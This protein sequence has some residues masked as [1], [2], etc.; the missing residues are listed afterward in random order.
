MG[1]G[2]PSSLRWIDR[3]S[4]LLVL[5]TTLLLL[6]TT[7]L[8][9]DVRLI[10]SA[11]TDTFPACAV[12]CQVLTQAQDACVPPSAPVSNQQTYV[13][14]F[15]QSTLLSNLKNNAAGVCGT[16][17]S[18]QAELVQLQKWYAD[19]CASGGK[20]GAATTTNAAPTPSRVTYPAPP[21]W[22][23]FY[24]FHLRYLWRCA[25]AHRVP[26]HFAY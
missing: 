2:L 18:N 19:Y 14:C 5:L 17:C 10:P 4:V 24:F 25:A 20:T 16:S 11:G 23:V 9:Q 26:D 15:C 21:P 22:Y 1:A 8:A 13:S 6:P 12:S 3:S 7:T